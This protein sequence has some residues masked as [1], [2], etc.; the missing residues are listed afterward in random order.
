M[1]RMEVNGVGLN[2]LRL[3]PKGGTDP[4]ARPPVVVCVHGVFIDSLAS[5][6]FTLGPALAAGGCEAVMFDLRGHGRSE[7][8]ES[9]YRIE[10]FIAD[11]D[12]LLDRL[13][14]DQPVHLVGNSFG[15][16]VALDYAA[17]HPERVASVLVI[18]S[19]P[20]T[21]DWAESMRGALVQTTENLPEDQ[22]LAWWVHMY[23][24]YASNRSGKQHEAHIARLGMSAAKLMRSTTIVADVPA[25]RLLTDEQLRSLAAPVL[26][27]NGSDGLVKEK[28]DWLL[29]LLP[30]VRVAEVPGQKHSVLVEAPEA[31]GKLV[32]EWVRENERGT[33]PGHEGDTAVTAPPAGGS[34]RGTAR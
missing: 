33:D 23:G 10:D 2:V 7:R 9:G 1:A 34:G 29:S 13:G 15:G 25:S 27:V 24:T 17:H 20:A 8:P 32:L 18:E 28:A 3:T 5:F 21:P 6:Y 31:V 16:T 12:A 30:R 11:L 26:L 14:I 22:A 19:G 4:D